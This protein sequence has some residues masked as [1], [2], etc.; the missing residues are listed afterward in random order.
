MVVAAIAADTATELAKA[1]AT[2]IMEAIAAAFRSHSR[3]HGHSGRRG[4]A[5]SGHSKSKGDHLVRGYFRANGT[6][7]A[8]HRARNAGQM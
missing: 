1:T 8:P 4:H 2:F 7:V 3:D 5:A 6:Y